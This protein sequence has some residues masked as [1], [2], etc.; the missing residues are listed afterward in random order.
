MHE[1]MKKFPKCAILRAMGTITSV[2]SILEKD[3]NIL[4]FVKSSYTNSTKPLLSAAEDTA[5]CKENENIMK[6]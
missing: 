3:G 2:N 6:M 4:N 1:S 5:G